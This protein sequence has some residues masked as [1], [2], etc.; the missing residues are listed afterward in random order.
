[1]VLHVLKTWLDRKIDIKYLC[2]WVAV[3]IHCILLLSLKAVRLWL[4]RWMAWAYINV[5]PPRYQP[6]WTIYI[7]IESSWLINFKNA[8]FVLNFWRNVMPCGA[9][10]Y[11]LV[12]S[13]GIAAWE[14]RH[15]RKTI[16]L[17]I[18]PNLLFHQ[19]ICKLIASRSTLCH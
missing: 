11:K 5:L 4:L 10:L 6:I 13:Q 3:I 7:S 18:F 1:M 14:Q 16:W 19:F 15:T 9:T 12:C 2:G 17:K 8:R